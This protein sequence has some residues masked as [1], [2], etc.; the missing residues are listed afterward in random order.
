MAL[1]NRVS[2]V[3]LV[4]LARCNGAGAPRLPYKILF[5][6]NPFQIEDVP[7]GKAWLVKIPL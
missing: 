5:M 3:A 7:K 4:S 2:A 6:L 1:S